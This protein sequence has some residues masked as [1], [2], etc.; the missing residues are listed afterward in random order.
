[1]THYLFSR[2]CWITAVFV[3][4]TVSVYLLKRDCD[5]SHIN[6]NSYQ[7]QATVSCARDLK[8]IL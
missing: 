7:L 6:Y 3:Y 8:M 5:Y 2:C 4:F 1:M